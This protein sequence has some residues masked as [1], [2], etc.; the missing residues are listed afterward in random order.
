MLLWLKYILLLVEWFLNA[1]RFIFLI[2][3]I[4][5]VFNSYWMIYYLQINSV[6]SVRDWNGKPGAT[7][8]IEKFYA[9]VCWGYEDFAI[10]GMSPVRRGGNAQIFIAPLFTNIL[11]IIQFY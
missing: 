11:F 4:G 10:K 7:P 9:K 3:L 8:F 2:L 1:N 6:F 5:D